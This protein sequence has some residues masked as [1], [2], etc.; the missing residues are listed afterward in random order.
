MPLQ[1]YFRINS[2]ERRPV[3]A[4]AD[5][6]RRGLPGALHRGLLGS[7]VHQRLAALGGR[8]DRRQAVGP[9]H[10]HDDPELVA[11]RLQPRHQA[12]PGRGRGPHGVDRR[13]H[14]LEADDEVPRRSTSSARRPPARCCR[15]PT[16]GAGQ[17]QDAGAKMVHAAPGDDVEDRVEV[18]QQGR[19][20]HHLS[21]P[22][23]RRRGRLRLQEPRAVRRADPRR[24]QSRAARSR[25][26]RSASATPQ[27]GHEAT[28]SK[29]ADEQLFYLMSRG[30]SQ[31]QAMGMVVNGFIEPITRTLPMEY[32]VE[33]SRLIELQMEGSRRLTCRL[34]PTFV[35]PHASTD[36]RADPERRDRR[37]SRG[38]LG[39]MPMRQ[40]CKNF[41]SRTYAERRDGAQ[42]QPRPGARRSVALPRALCQVRARL[43]RRLDVRHRSSRRPRPRSRPGSTTARRRRCSTRPRNFLNSVG[44][45]IKAEVAVEAGAGSRK[46][47]IKGRFR[48]KR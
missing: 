21:R 27:I 28:V 35:S 43:R 44:A 24:G 45:R 33:W 41:E 29:I 48:R 34:R 16:P 25:T 6:R 19:R 37:R 2:R 7:G 8:R 1:A 10:L 40:E 47:G 17:H 3:R 42:V 32:A 11:E 36:C 12:G 14:R 20:H 22:G 18:D 23:A 5:H 15:S 4:H 39:V 30:L 13:Q 26:W 38:I 46:R 31:E 9:G